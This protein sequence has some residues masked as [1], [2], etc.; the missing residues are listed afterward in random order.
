MCTS[1]VTIELMS[2]TTFKSYISHRYAKV[3]CAALCAVPV[4]C[5]VYSLSALIM[6]KGKLLL[7]HY[8]HSLVV[9]YGETGR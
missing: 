2:E 8:V 6:I 3:K 1:A 5:T 7:S 9:Q 4:Q